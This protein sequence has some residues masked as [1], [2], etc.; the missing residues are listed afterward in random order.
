MT[1]A[2]DKKQA[3]SPFRL[4]DISGAPYERGFQFGRACGDMIDRY[5][6]VLRRILAR[7]AQ[8]RDPSAQPKD[9]DR[10]ALEERAMRFLPLFESFAPE[11]VE[12]IRGIAAG[13]DV[14]FATALLVNVRGEV[15]VFDRKAEPT[16]GCTAFAAGRDATADGGILIAHDDR[17]APVS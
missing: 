12:E 13:A 11:Q 5:P 9:L 7:D 17:P 14:P 2:I 8:L 1:L 15:G 16:S 3:A 4:V 6:E 10:R